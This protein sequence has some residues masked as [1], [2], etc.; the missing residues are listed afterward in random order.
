[1]VELQ[2]RQSLVSKFQKVYRSK[3]REP[4]AVFDMIYL[5]PPPCFFRLRRYA[6]GS[7]CLH[8]QE[9]QVLLVRPILGVSEKNHTH[10]KSARG[11]WGQREAGRRVKMEPAAD[12]ATR[13]NERQVF[14]VRAPRGKN[15]RQISERCLR[16]TRGGRRMDSETDRR[17]INVHKSDRCS[18]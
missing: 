3:P 2:R 8:A 11:V 13:T 4:H 18:P 17:C 15:T 12:D 16:S 14:F 1:M 9:R 7:R 10:N 5:K 6:L